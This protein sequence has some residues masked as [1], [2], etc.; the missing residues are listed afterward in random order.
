MP[1]LNLAVLVACVVLPVA[2]DAQ[3]SMP[4]LSMPG[5]GGSG[6]SDLSASQD[7]LVAQYVGANQDVLNGDSQIADAIGLK[8]EAAKL[9]AL[10]TAASSG[11]TKSSMQ[12]NDATTSQAQADIAARLKS[13]PKMDAHAKAEYAK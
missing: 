2:A 5:S 11:A 13:D 7:K 9:H 10:A 1:R 12:D 4:K 6:G 3:F 8:D